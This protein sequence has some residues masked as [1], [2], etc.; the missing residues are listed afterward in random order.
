M[1]QTRILGRKIQV[2]YSTFRDRFS[3]G[4]DGLL[5]A[6]A[7]DA[8]QAVIEIIS[9]ITLGHYGRPLH[10]ELPAILWEKLEDLR[11]V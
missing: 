4:V 5:I 3:C 1:Y 8:K 6:E 9:H 10:F 2:N 7:P 11:Q